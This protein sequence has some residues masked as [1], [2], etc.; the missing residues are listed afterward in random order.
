MFLNQIVEINEKGNVANSVNF[1]MMDDA[2]MNLDLCESFIFNYD[3]KK[4]ELSSVGIL[5]AVRRSYHS[6]N[7][8]NIH[9]MIQQYGKGKSHFA[10]ALANF[11]QKPGNSAEVQGILQQ[12]AKAT[13]GKNNAIAELLKRFKHHEY[14][15]ICLSGDKGGNIKKQF[16]QA[17]VKSLQAAGITDSSAQLKCI[18]PLRYLE[19]LEAPLKAKANAYLQRI[20]N[21][22]GDIDSLIC[23]LKQNDSSVI[24]VVKNIGFELTGFTPDF[25]ANIDLE[26]LLEDLIKTY[27]SGENRC[28]QGILILFDELNYYLQS[29]AADQI[30]AGGSAVQN[31]TNICEKYKGKIALL[32]FTQ[33]HP[34]MAVGISANVK[35]SYFKI[36]S[37][38][39]PQDS[40]YNPA[41][42]LELVLDNLLIQKDSNWQE[43]YARW[44][45]TL[46]SEARTA[47]EKRIKIYTE[48]GW[49]FQDF[50][51]H[52]SL[53]CFPLHPLTAYLLCN[54]DF[55]QDRTAIQFIKGYVQKFIQT[56]PVEENGK[57]NYIYPVALVD[58]FIENFAND[59][60]Y[61]HYKKALNLVAVSSENQDEITV[62]KALFLFYA[63]GDK[64]T[65]IDREEHQEI[66][67]QLSG[68]STAN[69][70][71]ALDKLE[72]TRDVIYYRPETK[73]YRFWEG[74]TP[75]GIEA[76]IEE[77]I[78]D[79]CTSI[80]TVVAYV[81][82]GVFSNKWLGAAI[83]ATPFVHNNKLVG[84]N[85]QFEHK[86]YSIQGL[87][88]AL[89]SE[90][91]LKDTTQKGILAYVLA[92][93]PE[94]LRDLRQNI[95]NLLADS[96]IKAQIAVAIPNEETGDLAQILLKINTLR[97][98]ESLELRGIAYTQLL[99]RWEQQLNAQIERLLHSCTYHCVELAK[100][101]LREQ[102]KPKP[103]ISILLQE[104]YRFVPPVEE[105]DKMRHD[106]PTGSKIIS[107]VA[108]QLFSDS[109]T[110]QNISSVD[111]AYKTV[112]DSIFVR[113][114]GLLKKTSQ[115]YIVQEPTDEK[116]RAAW[117]QIS[118]LAAF[119]CKAEKV[120]E[121]VKIWQI[122]SSPPY[123]YSEYTFTILLAGWLAAH[124]QEVSLKGSAKLAVKGGLVSIKSLKDWA[125]A[126][127]LDKPK[128]F[129]SEWI[130]RRKAE[131]I[132]RQKVEIPQLPDLPMT[133]EQA[134]EYMTAVDTFLQSNDDSEEVAEVEKN[135]QQISADVKLIDAW[136][137]RVE[138][139]GAL[140]D[141]TTDLKMLLKVSLQEPRVTLVQLM[142]QQRERALQVE[143]TLRDKIEL[144]IAAATKRS[145]SLLTIDACKIY[146]DE[147]QAL[148]NQVNTANVLPRH[149]VDNLQNA[150]R[151]AEQQLVTLNEQAEVQQAIAE[152]QNL[153]SRFNND[154]TQQDYIRIRSEI[155]KVQSSSSLLGYAQVEQ[156][157]QDLEQRY[158][159]LSQSLETWQ[160]QCLQV[161]SQTQIL[162]LFKEINSQSR[163]FTEVA[164]RQKISELQQYLEQ[165]LKGIE[166]KRIMEAIRQY[167]SDAKINTIYLCDRAIN[168]IETLKSQLHPPEEFA[169]EIQQ[170]LKFVTAKATTHRQSLSDICDRLRTVKNITELSQIS[171][172]YAKLDFVF[173]DAVNYPDYQ[174]VQRQIQQVRENLEHQY[175]EVQEN[176][177]N[178]ILVL[179]QQ[180][181]RIEQQS[182]YQTLG[183]YLNDTAKQ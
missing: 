68:L 162:E 116:V 59:S 103:V 84:D 128:T 111:Q 135:K 96:P 60:M 153:Y 134:Q 43:F 61:T 108:K 173:K 107:F 152:I 1:G 181:P 89:A 2:Q 120:I 52:L 79:K 80:D 148:L 104:L 41:S 92:Q 165:K 179:F 183:Q 158:T 49:T 178:Q 11:F 14:L 155:E 130:V 82:Q 23:L 121:L 83:I 114:W 26:A 9:L 66:L 63:S 146:K 151:S 117:D 72:K 54:L 86:I 16:L 29:W 13:A 164:S 64:L 124:R 139:V 105:I 3:A 69:L 99:Q 142:P 48:K 73:T 85:W 74:I 94:E 129:V 47:F 131:L 55:T 132:R 138:Q 15:V 137:Q 157:L 28:F 21:P 19:K 110:S 67:C 159:E 172:D 123:G 50:S 18:E 42:S 46:L 22:D 30:G 40:T 36:S 156:I 77:E 109:L 113:S 95:D 127:I 112:V 118:Q 147:M 106:H 122:L 101:P 6:R 51:E 87:T 71:A 90:Q 180:L 45:N 24:S 93:T 70:K 125:S 160:A 150:Y 75:V 32:S 33:I 62:L 168:D 141:N 44:Q 176:K 91:T 35:D 12:V 57:L 76:E 27:C 10:V 56:K 154:S 182:L 133:Y 34:N 166:N 177:V 98:K 145:E 97:A 102:H 88:K 144:L 175:I 149:L 174:Q 143:R 170:I 119:P 171:T 31:I 7:E 53:G 4:P 38:L 161:T 39:A 167:K 58:S 17:A 136:L 25:D 126:D 37:R 65:K 8:P 81:G 163:R 140:L 78:K 169:A 5:D 115:K 100:I 20:D